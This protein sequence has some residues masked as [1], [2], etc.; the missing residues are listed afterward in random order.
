MEFKE[1]L[2]NTLIENLGIELIEVSADKVVGKMPVDKRTIQPAGILHG[3]ASV[4]FAETLASIGGIAN[5][6]YPKQV[7]V[8]ME[9]NANHLKSI[10]M[11]GSNVWVY[12]V[13]TPIHI[14]IKTQV[15]EIKLTDEHKKLVCISRATLA[16]LERK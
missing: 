1:Q 11:E 8:G 2:K 3:G 5:V 16:V 9:I 12:G 15:W 7:A 10:K 4:A 13:A 14:G 6:D